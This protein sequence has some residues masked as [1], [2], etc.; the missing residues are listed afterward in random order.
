M[1]RSVD[2]GSLSERTRDADKGD[3]KMLDDTPRS[4]AG[5]VADVDDEIRDLIEP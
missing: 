4:D 3:L 5:E 1:S 2:P